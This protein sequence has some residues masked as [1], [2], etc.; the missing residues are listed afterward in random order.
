MRVRRFTWVT[1]VCTAAAITLALGLAASATA[2]ARPGGEAG[3]AKAAAIAALRHLTANPPVTDQQVPGTRHSVRG[4]KHVD[5]YN[6]SGYANDNSKHNT[7]RKVSGD[8]TEP[9]VTCP[10]KELQA[11]VFWVGIDGFTSSTVEQDG[12]FAECYEGKAYYYTWWEMYPTNDIQMVGKTVKPGDKIAASV[13]RTGTSYALKLTDSTTKGNNIS[14]KETCAAKTCIDSSAEWIAE[15]PGGARG[16]FPLPDFKTWK[17]TGA[18]VTSGTKTGNIKTFP[19]D[20][21]TLFGDAYPLAT[22][23]ALNKAGT[24]FSDTWD[25]SY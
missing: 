19:D 24:G 23:G 11:A 10:T 9:A 3:A 5:Y 1:V 21:I 25:N 20:E 16:F 17:L 14:E 4:L 2:N 7:Y 12:T 22:P 15:T 8:W 6:W 18:S 13:V